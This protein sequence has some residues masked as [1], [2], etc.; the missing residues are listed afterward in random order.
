MIIFRPF[1]SVDASAL[2]DLFRDT[3]RRVNSRDYAPEQ[4]A[5]WSSDAIDRDLWASRF[6]GRCVWVA[7]SAGTL[8]GFGEMEADGHIDRFY[9]SADQQ[10]KGIG[11]QLLARLEGEARR[12]GIPKLTVEVSITALPFFTARGFRNL[13]RQTVQC[14][15]ICLDN[16]RMDKVLDEPGA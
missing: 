2:L 5:A 8:V 10:G 12:S 1:Q 7:E 13:G 9:V 15:G 14:R 6:S 11:G 3:V 16:Y 4:I